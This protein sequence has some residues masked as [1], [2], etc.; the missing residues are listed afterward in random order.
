MLRLGGGM[1]QF[2]LLVIFLLIAPLTLAE[3]RSVHS[4]QEIDMFPQG[5]MADENDWEFKRHLAFTEED[6]QEDGEYVHGMVADEHMT[7]GITLPEHLDDQTIWA[8]TTSTNSNASIG[9]PD[10]AYSWSTGPDITVGGFDVSALTANTIKSVELVVHFDIPNPLQQDKAR[11]S[12]VN[13]GIHDLVKTWSNTQGGLYYMNNGWS[14]AITNSNNWTW[15]E[16][17][18]IEVNLDYVS[19]GGTDDSQL[20]VDAVGIKV[21]MTTPWYG[22]ER[23]TASSINQFTEWPI[24]DLNILTGQLDSVSSAPCGL[25]SNSNGTWTTDSLELP[26]GQSWGRIHVEHN[27]QNGSIGIEYLD[28]QGA[29]VSI[30][31]GLIPSVSSDLQLRFTISDTCLSSA[32]VD[33]NDP[34]IRVQGSII[35]D[36]GS[37]VASATRW[38]IVV[39][40]ET[41]ANNNGTTLG[42]FDLQLP[43]GHAIDSSDTE[44]E[45]T[46][47]SWYNWAND[48]SP[49][50][51]N[52]KIHSIELIGAYSVDYDED[53]TCLL[54][55]SHELQED[56]GGIILPLLSRCTDD[57]TDVESLNVEF[58]NSD[59]NIVEVDLTEGQV[60]I[61]LVPE[62]SGTAQITTTVTDSAG[63]FWREVSTIN[64]ANVDDKPVLSEFPSVV[65]VEHG[66]AHNVP[67]TLTDS[68]SL[69]QDL[70]VTTNRSWATINMVEREIV[71]DA[72]TPGFTSVLVTACDES[73]CVERILDLEVRALAELFIEEIRIDNDNIKAGDVF[74]VKVFVRNSGQV[75]ATL[76]GVRCTADGQS[77]GSGTIQVLSPGQL[78]SIVCDMQA[79]DG[80]DSV[81][82]EAEV[83]RGTSIDEVDE[84]NNIES[85]VIAIGTAVE[86]P[87][88]SQDEEDLGMSQGMVYGITGG[89]MLLVLAIFGLLAPAKLKKIE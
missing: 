6:K 16:I 51:L 63:N 36:V 74:E 70:T 26:P 82:I 11:F 2:A 15:D 66:Y 39:N 40:G 59:P 73:N 52:L 30:E 83:D 45:V 23:V 41:I 75:T 3:A 71:I 77:F 19:N 87:T 38:T 20:Q 44:L 50:S 14:T 1:R 8:S 76:V 80:D 24:L 81:L 69:N 28:N 25:D 42:S 49:T 43:I 78:G 88:S 57:R 64:V 55:G 27:N 4:T 68:D 89:V 32:Q 86:E 84:G 61:K 67:F 79:P 29:W 21:T 12:V 60:R 9:S 54:I 10:G 5:D 13:S 85:K 37:M 22:A 18:N 47:K 31:E 34:H 58:Q 7:L 65:P 17:S 56:G 53:P 35:G 62:A 48:G 33:I 72:P 46:I